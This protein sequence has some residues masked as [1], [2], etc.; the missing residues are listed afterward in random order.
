M[1]Q[2]PGCACSCFEAS[3]RVM[4]EAQNMEY[5]CFEPLARR[6]LYARTRTGARFA[7]HST[8]YRRLLRMQRLELA[9]NAGS[10]QAKVAEQRLAVDA[11]LEE[12]GQACRQKS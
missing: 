4:R 5:H 12:P 8:A 2:N 6:K 3:A 9:K 10:N 7:S 11:R 1:L